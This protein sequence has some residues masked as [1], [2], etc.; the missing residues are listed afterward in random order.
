MDRM[1]KG[2]C[3][4]HDLKEIRASLGKDAAYQA[5]Y[6]TRERGRSGEHTA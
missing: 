3:H 2:A 1:P 6:L 4:G 5:R